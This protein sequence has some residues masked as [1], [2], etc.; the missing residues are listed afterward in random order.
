M[1][2]T[3]GPP[4]SDVRAEQ[5]SPGN[6]PP[7]LADP[8]SDGWILPTAEDFDAIG[9]PGARPPEP[10]PPPVE[11][12]STQAVERIVE[13]SAATPAKEPL[14]QPAR[15]VLTAIRRSPAGR[16]P[17][18]DEPGPTVDLTEPHRRTGRTPR[19]VRRHR[20]LAHR[21]EV[22]I[23][24]LA[25]AYWYFALATLAIAIVLP[26]VVGWNATTIMSNSM[27]PT[28]SAGDVVAFAGHDGSPL[29]VGTIVQFD[30]PVREGTLTHRIVEVN[31]DGS[32]QT[33]GDANRGPDSTPVAAES[34]IG[35]ARMVSPYAGLPHYWLTT[36][37]YVWLVAWILL[38]T[39]A[40]TVMNPGRLARK[41][42]A[43]PVP[44][45]KTRSARNP[46]RG[47]PAYPDFRS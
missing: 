41:E 4:G 5:G 3:A 46:A 29:G 39:A 43:R 44:E 17:P 25:T 19:W 1:T 35:V 15:S 16:E 23:T 45:I 37:R 13:P 32:Y 47:G 40:A 33:K 42:N 21:L 7:L 26:L 28:I 30:D 20:R 27:A 11:S 8:W 38:T 22:A 9:W 14:G 10:N 24:T 34:V 36:G 18:A 12:T 2:I 31:P 6:G